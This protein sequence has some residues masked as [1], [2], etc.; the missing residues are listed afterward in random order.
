MASR[1]ADDRQVPGMHAHDTSTSFDWGAAR[2]ALWSNQWNAPLVYGAVVF[3]ILLHYWCGGL[4]DKVILILP[5]VEVMMAWNWRAWPWGCRVFQDQER[6]DKKK[7]RSIQEK[8]NKSGGVEFYSR[9]EREREMAWPSEPPILIFD[10]QGI[11][12]NY[13]F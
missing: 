12:S 4:S 1:Q 9:K 5:L 3:R 10:G 8:I 7:V 6:K 13:L 2:G 11:A